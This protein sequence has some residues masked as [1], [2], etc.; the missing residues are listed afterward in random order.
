M[1]TMTLAGKKTLTAADLGGARVL[2]VGAARSGIALARFLTGHGAQVTLTDL[3]P[4]GDLGPQIPE[5]EGIGVRMELG[6]HDAAS[7]LGADLVAVSPG[8]PLASAPLAAARAKGVRVVAEVE[9]ASWFLKGTILGITGSNGKSTTT[10]LTGHILEQAGLSAV[11]C[12]N[13]G[14][15]LTELIPSDSPE[16]FYVVELSSFQLEGIETFHPS[17][18]ALLNLS[19]DH[20][21]RYPDMSAY[22][23]AKARLFLNQ[24]KGDDAVLNHDDPE[25]RAMA[26]ALRARIHWFSRTSR[27]EAGAFVDGGDIVLL[28]EGRET[29]V[30]PVGDLPLF[31]V[32][33]Q[34]N[35]LAALLMAARCGVSP[36]TAAQAVRAF[37]GL[38]HRLERVG[39]VNGVAWFNDSKATN[40]GATARS[41][42]SFAGNVVLILGGKDKGG[43]FAELEPLIRARVIHL[44]LM[45]QA[46]D[47]IARQLG[48]IAPTTLVRNLQ[49]A[50]DAA[51]RVAT[52][53]AVVLLAPA[54]ASFDQYSGFEAR[55]D[56]FRWLVND[57]TRAEQG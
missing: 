26:G 1:K 30:M 41:V 14:T 20:Q 18:A 46:R 50:V 15:P 8:V 38:P 5:L 11:A 25:V 24:E 43:A 34:E 6:G 29:R 57:L 21:D 13:L 39:E 4:A 23:A 51:A 3:R 44:I 52:P 2:V 53:G 36:A 32:H 56:H 12:G 10:A 37:R 16:R 22:Y 42:Q 48:P 45:G 47:D 9:V 55:G 28:A 49:E 35:V 19:P 27:L 40:V 33:N 54:C 31:G 7:F 17:I